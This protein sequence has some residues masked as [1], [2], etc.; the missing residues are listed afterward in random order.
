MDAEAEE[1]TM[2]EYGGLIEEIV[3]PATEGRAVV[4]EKGQILRIHQIT[5]AQVGDCGLNAAS[6]AFASS[7]SA[8]ARCRDSS[9]P[10]SF[11]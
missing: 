3:I 10:S 2:S 8:L 9:R 7:T 4:V 5:G 6:D 1:L 11:G